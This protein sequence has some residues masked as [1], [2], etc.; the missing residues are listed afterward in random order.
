[1]HLNEFTIDPRKEMRLLLEKLG[2]SADDELLDLAN[3]NNVVNAMEESTP[4]NWQLNASELI[5]MLP[6]VKDEI[7]ACGFNYESLLEETRVVADAV[8]SGRQ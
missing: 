7:K 4:G 5:G 2:L 6:L 1:M 3:E 8:A